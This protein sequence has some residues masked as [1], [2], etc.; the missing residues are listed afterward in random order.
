MGRIGVGTPSTTAPLATS[1]SLSISGAGPARC[2]FGAPAPAGPRAPLRIWAGVVRN[3]SGF[4]CFR[5]APRVGGPKCVWVCRFWPDSGGFGETQT[6]FGPYARQARVPAR[7]SDA[8]RTTGSL[9]HRATRPPGDWTTSSAP[10]P[11][12]WESRIIRHPH[13]QNA[14]TLISPG[15]TILVAVE[16][17]PVVGGAFIRGIGARGAGLGAVLEV[18]GRRVGGRAPPSS[19]TARTLP[20]SGT[21]RVARGRRGAA[22][23]RGGRR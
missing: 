4:R 10:P 13:T 9:G 15:D 18:R 6:L 22:G 5:R 7:S 11:D 19:G 2:G 21:A 8:F 12:Q 3:A 16:G 20:S 23:R 17:S 1:T 14:K